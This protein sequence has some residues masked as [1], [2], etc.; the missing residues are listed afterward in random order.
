MSLS[1]P[2]SGK[3]IRGLLDEALRAQLDG[4]SVRHGFSRRA[5]SL[6]YSRRLGAASQKIELT[7][8]LHPSDNPTASAAIYPYVVIDIPSITAKVLE[9][10][11]GEPSLDHYAGPLRQPLGWSSLKQETGRWFIYQEPSIL[12]FVQ[13][14]K[15]FLATFALPM[16][17]SYS[18]P[19]DAL[20]AFDRGDERIPATD[21]HHLRIAAAMLLLGRSEAARA[22]LQGRFGRPGRRAQFAPILAAAERLS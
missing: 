17:D 7:V 6:T 22:L 12:A 21:E 8:S 5:R 13:E 9:L 16:L 4:W 3:L 19:E 1:E 10:T 20:D 14:F 11:G 18:T 15:A 2:G